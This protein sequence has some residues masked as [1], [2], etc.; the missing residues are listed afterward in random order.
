VEKLKPIFR[1]IGLLESDGELVNEVGLTL[2]LFCL[3]YKR[4]NGSA[5]TQQLLA[6]HVLAFLFAQVLVKLHDTK[7]KRE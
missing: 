5:L 4:A 3:P 2:R 7:R 1:L 6:Q